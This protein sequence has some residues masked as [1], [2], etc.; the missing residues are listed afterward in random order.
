M[1]PGLCSM[2][3]V[4]DIS[5]P[6]TEAPDKVSEAVLL[7]CQARPKIKRCTCLTFNFVPLPNYYYI[8]GYWPAVLFT[9]AIVKTVF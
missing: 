4:E 7:F 8:S 6:L 9:K 5:E 1:C 2:I 3:E